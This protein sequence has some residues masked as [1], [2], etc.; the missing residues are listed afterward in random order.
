MSEFFAAIGRFIGAIA[1]AILPALI[2]ESKK[3]KEIVP[4]GYDKELDADFDEGFESDIDDDDY[5]YLSPEDYPTEQEQPG[6]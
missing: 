3:P 6:K 5:K 2:K 4:A 1:K